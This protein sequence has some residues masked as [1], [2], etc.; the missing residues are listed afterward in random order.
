MYF[1]FYQ[2]VF[3]QLQPQY[4]NFYKPTSPSEISNQ[5]SNHYMPV[6]GVWLWNEKTL[7]PNGYREW[8]DQVSQHSPYN[9][10]I[11]FLRF[12]DNEVVDNEVHNQVKLA[13]DYASERN[14]GL[15]P[16][17]DVRNARRAFKREYPQE[18]QEMLRIKEI[19]LS[20][21]DS[22]ETVVRS[23]DLSDHYSGGKIQ[24][25]VSLYGSLLRVY[26]YN[27]VSGSVDGKSVK[28]I[29][30]ECRLLIPSKDSLKV[31]IPSIKT[32]GVTPTHASVMVS[33]THLYPDVYAPHLME[34][35]HKIIH[36]YADARLAGACKD[37][38]GF[39]PYFPRNYREGINDFWYSK[40]EAQAYAEKTGGR[41]LLS[42]CFLMAKGIKGKDSERQKAINH[43]MEMNRL[44]NVTL[45]A[46]FYN[47]VKEVFG[48]DAAVT[49]HSTWWPYPDR[50]EFKKN[51]LDW[52]ATK[53]DWAQTDE[54]AP[55]AVRTALCKKWGSPIWYNMYYKEDISAQQWSSALGGGRIDYLPIQSLYK[56]E[57]MR[58][59]SRIR[60]LNYI[61]KSPLDC[62]IA[63]IFGHA[64]AMNWAGPYHDD[65]GMQLVDSLWKSGYP[66]DLIPTSEIDN[67]S[68]RVDADG[69]IAYGTQRY[70][71]V[72]LYH[73]EFEKKST[74]DFFLKADKGNTTMLR[75]GDWTKDFNASPIVGN[76]LLP[77]SMLVYSSNNEASRN[78][79]EIVKKKGVQSQSPA[80]GILDNRYFHLRDFNHSSCS[81]ATTGFSRLIDGTVI[82]IAGTKNIS[83][84]TIKENFKINDFSVFVD[85]VGVAAVRVDSKGQPEALAASSLKSF[86]TGSFEINLKERLDVALWKDQNGKWQGIIQGGTGE[87]PAELKKLTE[88]WTHLKLPTPCEK[89]TV[90]LNQ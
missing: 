19:T 3:C 5:I 20:E 88:N 89:E 70:D 21:T 40:H 69:Y 36:Q 35:Q 34:F 90:P 81:P 25:H 27:Y 78:I 10:L 66:A 50:N 31:K 29:T 26:A 14:V 6:I 55:Y 22:M 42:D 60:L 73:P 13:A 68:L 46:D 41:E 12:P 2:S 16:D 48:P 38:W 39:P 45:E 37:E 84:D 57:V 59:E 87:I 64:C 4:P 56:K 15:V 77:N 11:P 76:N 52:W 71:A 65:V 30:K 74:S 18:L 33:F 82:Q 54:V 61:S 62:R 7:I 80:T 86:K 85:A 63:V 9:L 24:H 79:L 47:A 28:D 43:F 75:I 67:G 58:A 23:I 8:I 17:L 83:G 51:G 72:V 49:V 53:R 32:N 1:L 44:R